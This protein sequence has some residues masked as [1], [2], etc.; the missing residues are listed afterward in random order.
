MSAAQRTIA[1][2]V[3]GRGRGHA[4]RSRQI[5]ERLR[6]RGDRI[7]V[8]AG[9][10]AL[11]LLADLDQVETID[12]VAPGPRGLTTIARRTRSDRRRLEALGP[13]VV[14]SDGDAPSLGA[15][16]LLGLPT[17]AIGHDLVFARCRLP[18]DLPRS[19]VWF[20][21][22]SAA[23]SHRMADAGVAVHF[24]PIEPRAP[25]TLVA[26]PDRRDDLPELRWEPFIAAYFRDGDGAALADRLTAL[27]VRVE[28]FGASDPAPRRARHHGFDRA[29]F[30]DALARC[31]GVIGTA[32]SNLLAE[33]VLLGKPALAVHAAGD[34]EQALNANLLARAGLGLEARIDDVSDT[35]LRTFADRALARDFA[36]IDLA[37]ALPPA[38]DAV[39]TCLDD[40]LAP[41]RR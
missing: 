20:E 5:V 38:S 7:V 36:T 14:V 40:L 12:V 4:S 17:L 6:A 30:A 23:P 25:R 32:G 18:D 28:L 37:R 2:Y 13:D 21:K 1:W 34:H 41:A 26:R 29:G 24:L 35:A 9:G 33:C 19:S 11:D 39:L 8:M 27:G 22:L 10:D 3:H 31:S 16:R 15:A